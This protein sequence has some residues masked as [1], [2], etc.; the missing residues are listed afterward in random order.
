LRLPRGENPATR[1]N[2]LNLERGKSM[3][4]YSYECRKCGHRFEEIL[5]FREY[6]EKKVKCPKCGSRNV[7]QA[8]EPFFAKTSR[9]S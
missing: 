8:L 9:K 2:P 4:T 5:T 1:K 3:P 6:G 7:A